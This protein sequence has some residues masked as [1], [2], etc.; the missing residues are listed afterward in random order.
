MYIYIYHVCTFLNVVLA[1]S[2]CF[3]FVSKLSRLSRTCKMIHSISVA[4]IVSPRTDLWWWHWQTTNTFKKHVFKTPIMSVCDQSFQWTLHRNYYKVVV[5]CVVVVVVD[6]LLLFCCCCSYC[7]WCN[8]VFIVELLMARYFALCL[9]FCGF[10]K[11]NS[12]LPKRCFIIIY[13]C[14]T[15]TYS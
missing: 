15:R 2:S 11:T 4:Q 14:I 6:V 7:R 10:L 5:V 13:A 3:A 12:P 9:L 8:F 1:S